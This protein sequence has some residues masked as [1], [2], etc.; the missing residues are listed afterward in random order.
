M[1]KKKAAEKPTRDLPKPGKQYPGVHG[2][3]VDWAEHAFE[4]G[5]MYVRVRGPCK[6]GKAVRWHGLYGWQPIWCPFKCCRRT[7]C[8]AGE[9]A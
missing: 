3:I 2:K 8:H 1:R 5:M 6:C 4:E 9:S 7:A